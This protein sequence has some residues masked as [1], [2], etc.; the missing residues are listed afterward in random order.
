[1]SAV[2]EQSKAKVVSSAENSIFVKT[3]QMPNT[4][5]SMT[6]AAHTLGVNKITN[7]DVP[8]ILSVRTMILVPRNS[9][10]AMETN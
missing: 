10:K 6:D 7:S 1:M 8:R 5:G 4:T 9:L 3:T 2:L